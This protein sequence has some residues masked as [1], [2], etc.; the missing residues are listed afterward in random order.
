MDWPTLWFVLLGVLLAGYAIL[1]AYNG[2][3]T[4]D[5][6]LPGAPRRNE[7]CALPAIV[8][9]LSALRGVDAALLATQTAAN[10]A[11]LF[12]PFEADSAS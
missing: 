3:V 4:E 7:P 12:G 5:L 2:L 10:A 1:D 8:A 11:A 9:A 6:A